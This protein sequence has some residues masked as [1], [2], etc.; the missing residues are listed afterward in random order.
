MEEHRTPRRLPPAVRYL[1]ACAA[2]VVAYA[3][4]PV[5]ADAGAA[6]LVLRGALTLAL[7]VLIALVIGRQAVRQ[8]REPDAPLGTL[9]VGIVA[10]LLVFALVDYGVAVHRPEEFSGLRTRV[11]ALY[12]ALSTLLTVGFG[13]VS[14][15]G[16]VARVVMCVQMAF[17]FTAIAGSASL[18]ARNFAARAAKAARWPRPKP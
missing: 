17:N 4:V 7:L 13:D 1:L 16:Q 3:V 6:A 2:L 5:R 10:G 15:Q 11:D 18:V 12:F 8:L 14:A 9:V